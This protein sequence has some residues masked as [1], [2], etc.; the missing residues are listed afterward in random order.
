[1]RVKRDKLA[2]FFTYDICFMSGEEGGKHTG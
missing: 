2:F 1:M